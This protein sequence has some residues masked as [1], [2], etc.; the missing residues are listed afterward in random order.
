MGVR[1]TPCVDF[2]KSSDRHR[3]PMAAR[4]G[5][6]NR[7][8]WGVRGTKSRRYEQCS[9][10]QKSCVAWPVLKATIWRIQQIEMRF[11]RY[12]T[13][14]K[15]AHWTYLVSSV[16]QPYFRWFQFPAG[17]YFRAPRCTRHLVVSQMSGIQHL[18]G[19]AS[20]SKVIIEASYSVHT[21]SLGY[22]IEPTILCQCHAVEGAA[23]DSNHSFPM[24]SGDAIIILFSL[25]H[26][27]PSTYHM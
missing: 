20:I 8:S 24:V 23:F 11:E 7:Q 19:V 26:S 13:K 2:A 12:L 6:D 3:M 10:I 4:N 17:P 21:T 1:P 9:I 27:S 5:L 14:K 16:V 15:Q 22:N 25:W 18:S